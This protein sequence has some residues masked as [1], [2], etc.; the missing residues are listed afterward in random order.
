MGVNWRLSEWPFDKENHNPNNRS[1]NPYALFPSHVPN[2]NSS[3][4]ERQII[5]QFQKY[6]MPCAMWW[7]MTC[8]AKQ[9]RPAVE[10]YGLLVAWEE[11]KIKTNAREFPQAGRFLLKKN[12]T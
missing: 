6:T 10:T 2:Y 1:N 3:P 8:E 11:E 7:G 5:C 4:N 12:S 9:F